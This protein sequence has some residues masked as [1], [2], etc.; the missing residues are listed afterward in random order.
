MNRTETVLRTLAEDIGARP[1]GT[2]ANEA[3]NAYLQGMA[4][5]LGYEVTEL[6]FDCRR[7]EY[8]PSRVVADSAAPVPI[9]PGPFSAPLR[10]EF[11]VA[12]VETLDDLRSLQ[13]RGSVLIIRGELAAEPLM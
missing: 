2:E 7:W 5:E 12:V 6:H 13:D 9:Q 4:W 3:A 10:G 11:P 8:G 1:T